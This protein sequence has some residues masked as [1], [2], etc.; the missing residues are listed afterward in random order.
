M[1]TS[2]TL[3]SIL[4]LA[5][6]TYFELDG[7][8]SCGSSGLEFDIDLVCSSSGS[9]D[10]SYGDTATV[11]GTMVIPEG[12]ISDMVSLKNKACFMGIQSSVTCQSYDFEASLCGLFDLEQ[13]GCPAAGEYTLDGEF[14]FPEDSGD[15]D[16]GSFWWNTYITVYTT[17]TPLDEVEDGADELPT[18]SCS[19]QVNVYKGSVDNS[20]YMMG[21]SAVMLAGLGALLYKRRRTAKIDLTKE[22]AMLGDFEMMNDSVR[23]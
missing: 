4:S 8:P 3:L 14:D 13:Y 15:V 20:S 11:S 17:V 21:F 12:G 19:T 9:N 5:S 2:L 22:E 7:S 16:L 18:L 6:A 23:V 10:C 1:K